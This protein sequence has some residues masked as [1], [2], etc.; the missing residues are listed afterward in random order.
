MLESDLKALA[1]KHKFLFS[2]EEKTFDLGVNI[3]NVPHNI[4]RLSKNEDDFRVKLK[5]EFVY[6]TSKKPSYFS[7]NLTDVTSY[8]VEVEFNNRGNLTDFYIM[9]SGLF[10]SY[11]FKTKFKVKS[12]DAN[13][14][15]YLSQNNE[16]NS[17]YNLSYDSAEISPLI[18]VKINS[19][20]VIMDINYQSFE[21]KLTMLD[22]IL[23]FCTRLK[24]YTNV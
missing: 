13:L 8:R 20:K 24:G 10:Q 19:D 18:E 16:L 1:K 11:F 3:R 2:S 12:K 6:G 23:Q 17:I 14:K 22:E 15:Q 21:T 7:G 5:V 4:I 9:P